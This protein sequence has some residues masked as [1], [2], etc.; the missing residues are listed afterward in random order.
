[1]RY[2][3]GNAVAPVWTQEPKPLQLNNYFPAKETR[4]QYK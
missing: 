2:A 1:M 4:R 3:N